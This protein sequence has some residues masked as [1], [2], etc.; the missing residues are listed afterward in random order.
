MASRSYGILGLSCLG[1]TGARVRTCS[2]ISI[3]DSP[4][5]GDWL[6]KHSY[7]IRPRAYTSVGGPRRAVSP[8]ACSGAM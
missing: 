6:V 4:L 1:G 3:I 7:K 2:S 8:V 5:K